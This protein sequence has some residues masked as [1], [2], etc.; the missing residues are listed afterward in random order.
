MYHS[1]PTLI[2]KMP[3]PSMKTITGHYH[4]VFSC[5]CGYKS[6][7][8]DTKKALLLCVRL[9]KKHCPNDNN[10]KNLEIVKE[11]HKLDTGEKKVV[12]RTETTNMNAFNQIESV[13]VGSLASSLLLAPSTK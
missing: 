8:Y 10:I 2:F 9:H 12:D 5:G 11:E 4:G 7:R 13:G 6:R 1:T 3:K